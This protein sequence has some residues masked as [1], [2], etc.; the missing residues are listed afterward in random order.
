MDDN[1]R[2]RIEQ[3]IRHDVAK[4]VRAKLGFYWHAAVYVLVNAGT[5]AINLT[6]TPDTLW[7]VW[8]LAGWGI[9]LAMHAFAVAQHGLSASMIDAEVQRE[10]AKRGI[11]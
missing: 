5:A 7:F 10:L 3:E 2:K 1:E 9:G 8:P 4:R 6:Q 11:A